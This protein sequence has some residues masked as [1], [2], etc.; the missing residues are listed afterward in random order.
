MQAVL[1]RTGGTQLIG[2]K[3][4]WEFSHLLDQIPQ[5]DDDD[6]AQSGWLNA[7]RYITLQAVS[8]HCLTPRAADRAMAQAWALDN[9]PEQLLPAVDW[10]RAFDAVGFT[11][12]PDDPFEAPTHPHQLWRGATFESRY[13]L[14]WTSEAHIARRFADNL[15]ARGLSGEVFVTIVE[16]HL[17]KARYNT[18]GDENEWVVDSSGLDI[19]AHGSSDP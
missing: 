12:D 9:S 17:V 15:R 16:P 8:A 19:S 1:A 14:A 18:H 11:S 6:E 13:G 2:A 4:E 10:L 3:N 7:T 5:R